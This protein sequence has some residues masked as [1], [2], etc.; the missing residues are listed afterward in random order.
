MSAEP[1]RPGRS[2]GARHEVRF[3]DEVFVIE[4]PADPD[5]AVRRA[6]RAGSVRVPHWGHLWPMSLAMARWVRTSL[7][8]APGGRV[9][10]V[11]CGLGLV[12][13]VAAARR[14][15]VTMTDIEDDALEWSAHNARL[16]GVEVV[17]ERFDWNDPPGWIPGPDLLL[18]SDVLYE[19]GSHEAIA[20]LI[21]R[22]G[23]PAVLADP[24]RANSSGAESV[25]ASRG[26]RCTTTLVPGGRIMLVRAP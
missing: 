6:E 16:N 20:T 3:G 25:F 17:V 9:T 22:A 7:L 15:S 14:A 13:I 5:G 21:E 24:L 11:G 26:L 10:E 19:P 4:G 23:C 12:G 8:V 2:P 18:A 1:E